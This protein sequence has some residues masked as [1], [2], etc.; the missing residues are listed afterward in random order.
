MHLHVHLRVLII[1][2]Q[3]KYSGHSVIAILPAHEDKQGLISVSAFSLKANQ[4]Q[5]DGVIHCHAGMIVVSL[6]S[7]AS[8]FS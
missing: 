1:L 4:Q 3:W 7:G 8:G 6:L 5:I 2:G